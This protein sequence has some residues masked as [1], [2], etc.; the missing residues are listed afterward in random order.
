MEGT[1]H[2][3]IIDA[4]RIGGFPSFGDESSWGP[5]GL[6]DRGCFGGNKKMLSWRLCIEK[7]NNYYHGHYYGKALWLE[8]VISANASP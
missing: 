2:C 8:T 7:R 6:T 4:R 1:G 5:D 3:A